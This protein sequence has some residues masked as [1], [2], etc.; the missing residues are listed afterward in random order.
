[1]KYSDFKRFLSIHHPN[2]PGTWSDNL[3]AACNLRL[4]KFGGDVGLS[5]S[6]PILERILPLSLLL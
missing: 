6:Q 1:M 3:G 5:H 4:A 2:T